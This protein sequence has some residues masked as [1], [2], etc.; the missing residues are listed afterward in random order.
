MLVIVGYESML[1][2][3]EHIYINILKVLYSNMEFSTTQQDRIITNV[4]GIFIEFDVGD[5]SNSKHWERGV[6][7]LHF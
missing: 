5:L 6:R 7:D 2:M 3:E 1:S 4:S